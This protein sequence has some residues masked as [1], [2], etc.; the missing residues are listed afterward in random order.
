MKQKEICPIARLVLEAR[1]LEA[2]CVKA[3]EAGDS[4]ESMEA[5]NEL[6]AIR[7]AASYLRPKSIAGVQF[8]LELIGLR[9]DLMSVNNRY[10]ANF[11]SVERM[12]E[13]VNTF[14]L[15]GATTKPMSNAA[16]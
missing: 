7:V 12:A 2:T 1:R 10:V 14:L 11:A 5:E 9:S 6:N 15:G 3:D 13:S 8:L 4:V 16:R